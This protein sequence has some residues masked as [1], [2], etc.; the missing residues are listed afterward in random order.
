MANP[1]SRPP[2]FPAPGGPNAGKERPASRPPSAPRPVDAPG[3]TRESFTTAPRLELP[4]GGGAI[5]GIGETFKANPAT[6]TASLSVP[7]PFSLGRQG[8]TPS[9]ALSYDSGAGNGPCG[10]G[11]SLGVPSI[12]RKTDKKL[13]SYRDARDE[14]TFVLAGAEDLV[15]ALVPSGSDWAEP[16]LPAATDGTTTWQR[17]RYRPRVDDGGTRVERWT[18]ASGDAH[19][20]AWSRDG[21]LRIFGLSASARLA[22][23]DDATRVFA[24]Y[25]EEERDERGNIIKYEY[26]AEDATGAP[27]TQAESTRSLP[28]HGCTYT[29]LKRV[30]HGNTTPFADDG[31]WLFELV[32]DHGDH[33]GSGTASPPVPPLH[34]P[35]QDWPARQDIFSSRRP[36]FDWRC[37][38]LVRRV[39][40]FHRFSDPSAATTAPALV[41]SLELE[42]DHSP[43]A[44]T[45]ASV[46]LRGW[47]LESGTWTTETMPALEFTYTPATVDTTVH[48]LQG[49]EDLPRGLDAARWQWQDLDGEGMQGLL[50]EHGGRWFFKR[51][52]GGGELGP[53]RLVGPRPS[54]G[55]AAGLADVDGDGRLEL[56]SRSPAFHGLA[57]RADDGTWLPPRPFRQV[58]VLDWDSRAMRQLDLDGDG[59]PDL[60]VTEHDC[61]TW[62][63]SLGREGWDEARR[64]RHRGD[65]DLSPRVLFQSGG[66]SILLAD[67]DGDGLTDIVRVRNG[68][69]CYWPSRG[70]GRFGARVQMQG[71]PRMDG[72][73]T[74]D[75]RRV[76]LAD[77][78]GSGPAD[79]IYLGEGGA[80]VYPNC[81]GNGFASATGTA[82]PAFPGVDS[83]VAVQVADLLGD[84]TACMVWSSPLLR[85]GWAPVRY[86]RLMAEGK[87]YLLKTVTN[88][89]GRVTTLSYAPSTQY[90]L[91]DRLAGRPWATRLH[92]PVQC[93]ASVEARDD[94]TGWRNTTTYA[95][96]HGYFDPADREFRGFGRVEQWDTEQLGTYDD[97]ARGTG[98]AVDMPP[99]RTVS[100]FHTGAWK[101]GGTLESAYAAE[102]WAGDG[103]PWPG[104]SA[105]ADAPVTGATWA[106]WK[107]AERQEAARALRGRL[108]RQE[109]YAEDGDAAEGIPYLAKAS[110]YTVARAQPPGENAHASFLVVPAET[111]E[112]HHE[113]VATDPRTAHEI[114]LAF[115]DRGTVTRSASIAYPRRDVPGRRDEQHD[116]SVKVTQRDVIHDDV[117]LDSETD[118][119]S[120]H[121]HRGHESR[122]TAWVLTDDGWWD[123][124]GWAFTDLA[125]FSAADL[126]LDG[127]TEIPFEDEPSTGSQKRAIAVQATLYW[128]DDLSGPATT[129]ESRALVYEKYQKCIT[130][131]LASDT[132]SSLPSTSDFE[133][134]GHVDLD[135]DG[136][137]WVPSGVATLDDALFYQPVTVTGPFGNATTV[138]WDTWGLFPLSVTDPLGNEV[139]VVMDE[140]ALQPSS[141]R[142]PNENYTLARY[143]ALGRLVAVAVQGKSGEGLGDTLA[144]PTVA[145]AYELHRWK[146]SGLPARA[147]TTLRTVHGGSDFLYR[148]AYS[149]G[150]GNLVQEKVSAEPGDVDGVA[151]DPRWVGTG[152]TV[153]NN[154]GLPAR[155]YEPYFSAT[156]ECEFDDEASAA[157]VSSTV[158]YDPVGRARKV[159]LPSGCLRKVTFTPWEQAFHDENDTSA[160]SDCTADA[161]LV[162]RAAA[163]AG[164]PTTV[165]LDHLGRPVAT[166]ELPDNT[167]TTYTTAVTLDDSGNPVA[168]TDA[169]DIVTQSQVFDMLGRPL[170]EVSPDAGTT[171]TFMDVAGNPVRTWRSGDLLVEAGYDA[172]RRRTTLLVTE[173]TATPRL[174]EVN[175]YGEGQGTASN[176]QGRLWR[177]WDTAGRVV[178]DSYDFE[179]N[180]ALSTRRFW[181]W[182][183]SGEQVTW[184]DDAADTPSDT[185]LETEEFPTTRAFDALGRVVTQTTRD[186]SVTTFTYNEAS[187]LET[188]EVEVLGTTPA[189]TF[190]SGVEYNARGQRTSITYGNGVST[191]YTY[192]P[193]TF[194]LSRLVT[195]RA[196]DSAVLQDLV[197]EHDP[198]G[199]ITA[200]ANDADDTQYFN[201]TAVS[202]DQS[203]AYD[204]TYRLIEATGRERASL[205]YVQPGDE[206]A[207][208]NRPDVATAVQSYT[209]SYTYDEAGNITEMDHLVG[210]GSPYNWTRAY[211]YA[212]DSNRL[213]ST[214]VGTTTESFSH[215]ARGSIVYLPSLRFSSSLSA[216]IET[217][218]RD[219]A[220]KVHLA[221]SGHYALYFYDAAGQRARKV[222]VTDKTV[223]RIYIGGAWEVYRDYGSGT[224]VQQERETLHVMDGEQRVAMVETL[225]IEDGDEVVSPS[226][227]SRYQLGNH[228]GSVALELDSAGSIISYEEYH[229]HGT[230]AWRA[231][232][233]ATVSLKRYRYTGMERDPES[234]LQ[235]H[236]RRYY[237][238]WLGRWLSADPIGVGDGVNRYRYCHGDP[239]GRDDSTGLSPLLPS[240]CRSGD[241]VQANPPPDPLEEV[242]AAGVRDLE[243]IVRELDAYN[244]TLGTDLS[245]MEAL[246]SPEH[247]DAFFDRLAGV[248]QGPT[249]RQFIAT[250]DDVL[251]MENEVHLRG[252]D[253]AADSGERLPDLQGQTLGIFVPGSLDPGLELKVF[254]PRRGAMDRDF[255]RDHFYGTGRFSVHRPRGEAVDSVV[256]VNLD[257]ALA[258]GASSFARE[259]E[260]I[261]ETT[262]V[263]ETYTMQAPEWY[264]DRAGL[265]KTW[266]HERYGH[267][268]DELRTGGAA[269]G[270][271]GRVDELERGWFG[272]RGG[273]VTFQGRR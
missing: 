240:S 247:S 1:P 205:G 184:G 251:R 110:N 239:V 101:Q 263:S 169:R 224:S 83:A 216:N 47:K 197:Y 112:R 96:G 105:S 231:P 257:L 123:G 181:D 79:L 62:Y 253:A 23:P 65:E 2:A 19:W 158:Y 236:G 220:R 244:A 196:S 59:L 99:V 185:D 166:D 186:G 160:D 104:E 168:I 222:V 57:P 124:T 262:R 228:L 45:L 122:V 20:R 58:P 250:L 95:Y 178:H 109:V 98:A 149:D 227:V 249:T 230:T 174:V 134:A 212:S 208:G 179:G 21:T 150:A 108:L 261:G 88:N 121:W 270:R 206:P 136:D 66:E 85:D 42:Y 146:D 234:G 170:Q 37:R 176:H 272:W 153:F 54:P 138:A 143:D 191:A 61:I 14:D 161:A 90:M 8:V 94:V 243:A 11:W 165:Y 67:M 91:S 268:V 10:L 87:P 155:Q 237:V 187:L 199:N 49:V 255:N 219:Q 16:A 194:R 200:I 120:M 213:A 172:L 119:G 210:S 86:V 24:W 27:A 252:G 248:I 217:D 18:T 84:G 258:T 260:N 246:A 156:E 81:A 73:D 204:A 173:G 266:G 60:L 3:K 144:D 127:A 142:D 97:P 44:T 38:R 39:L 106:S 9:L 148:H 41:K 30:L 55:S 137:W 5:K 15:P 31:N 218:F 152:R 225:T 180:L 36:G 102:Y 113:R 77:V 46:T 116:L 245:L 128:K 242:A 226:P 34:E 13:P 235:C 4:R 198:V 139:V 151:T 129:M 193:D 72:T 254:G 78:D 70:H 232:E 131:G 111:I 22:D 265:I 12:Q 163:H 25:L 7:L 202:P 17:R 103:A 271:H 233:L 82:L 80:T 76:R 203:F 141:V 162:A 211:A 132:Y 221:T 89:L 167:G 35:D 201:A 183:A 256:F 223:E 33:S 164:T 192:D 135:G 147:S 157:G 126:D 273:T 74:F 51:N 154:K 125:P 117:S 171:T 40:A 209:Q 130:S 175:E 182:R 50:A 6:G 92:F 118:T 48:L 259:R 69:V 267:G 71:S 63:P 115:D 140:G 114:T 75:P 133:S 52:E 53:A 207:Y 68:S 32:L 238:P 43:V 107:P 215:D 93:L 159:A 26:Q 145:H 229:P 177:Q 190:V 188:V 195:T 56:L 28:G 269:S 29:Y 100:W 264:Q 189:T 241:D 64:S 214:T